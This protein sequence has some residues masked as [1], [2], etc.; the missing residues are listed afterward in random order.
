MIFTYLAIPQYFMQTKVYNFALRLNN[1]AITQYFCRASE[2]NVQPM[3]IFSLRREPQ[4][5]A[6][7]QSLIRESQGLALDEIFLQA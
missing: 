1:W 7:M 4:H 5:F 2:K 6:K 3:R